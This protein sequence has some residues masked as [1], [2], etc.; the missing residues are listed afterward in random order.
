M[1]NTEPLAHIFGDHKPFRIKYFLDALVTWSE[2]SKMVR[3]VD[4]PEFS[5]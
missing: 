1:N 3:Y 4:L 5:E 2:R